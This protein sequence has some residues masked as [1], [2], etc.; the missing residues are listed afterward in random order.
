[1]LQ[2]SNAE[3]NISAGMLPDMFPNDSQIQRPKVKADEIA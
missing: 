1:M 2:R 3:V